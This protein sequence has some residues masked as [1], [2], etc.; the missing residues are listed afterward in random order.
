MTNRSPCESM[1]HTGTSLNARYNS[2]VVPLEQ[3]NHE[4]PKTGRRKLHPRIAVIPRVRAHVAFL[5][6]TTLAADVL[7]TADFLAFVGLG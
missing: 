1:E 5:D 3:N 6:L 4:E 2:G 7:Q